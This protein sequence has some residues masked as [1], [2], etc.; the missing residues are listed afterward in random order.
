[1]LDEKSSIN[2]TAAPEACASLDSCGISG[3]T[4][5]G[6]VGLDE[7]TEKHCSLRWE[8]PLFH[9]LGFVFV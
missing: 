6:L 3:S 9:S 7:C 2:R 4:D 8:E 1:M 5:R